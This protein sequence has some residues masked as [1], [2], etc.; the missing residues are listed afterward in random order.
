MT[1]GVKKAK[2][3]Y[4]Q[5]FGNHFLSEAIEGALPQGQNSPQKPPYGLYAEQ[6]SGSAFTALRHESLRTWT[7][8]IRPSVLHSPFQQIDPGLLRSRPFSEVEASPD[9]MRWEPLPYPDIKVD[10]IGALTTL[11]GNGSYGTFRGSAAHVYRLNAAMGS[12]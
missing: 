2:L 11:E 9:L 5:G 1:T 4:Q 7:Y 12:R 6:I 8:R 3:T 10:F